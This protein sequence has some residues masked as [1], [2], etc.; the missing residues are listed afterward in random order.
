MAK[1]F[2]I[3]KSDEYTTDFEGVM[4]HLH[5]IDEK[6]IEVFEAKR[7]IN[8]NCFFCNYFLE[9]GEKG[10][11]GKSCESYKPRNGKKG[12]CI[13]NRSVYERGNKVKFNLN[14]NL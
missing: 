8:A 11:C 10:N 5:S 2:F 12:I 3:K 1:H 14:P 9:V 6:E 13:H 4:D 7:I